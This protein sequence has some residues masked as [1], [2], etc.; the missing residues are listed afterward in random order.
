M[1]RGVWRWAQWILGT[2]IL[3]FV[4][5]AIV[6][7]WSELQAQP[8][9]WE[10]RP[11][12]LVAAA[13][14]VWAMYA[15]LIQAW[16]LMLRGWGAELPPLTAA[17]I[18]MVSNLGKY[19][20]GKVW[21]IAGMAMMSQRAGVPGWAATASAVMLQALAMG[22]GAVVVSLTGTAVLAADYPWIEP[23]LALLALASVAGIGLLLWPPFVQ[24]LLGLVGIAA[25]AER[26]PMAPILFGIVANAV[27]WTGYGA[28]L[29]LLA[30]GILPDTG[31]T[32]PAAIGAFTA[33]YVAGFLFLVAPG[34]VGV[35]ESVMVLMLQGTLGLG[36]AGALAVAS[37]LLLTLT[38]IGA[39]IPFL[40]TSRER[41]RVVNRA[42]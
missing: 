33:S 4:A 12:Y 1:R 10:L 21:T 7:N 26:M 17:R 28:A 38:E 32:L 22:T 37:R 31:L 8:L 20:P 41:S 6:R 35:R 25:P 24:R 15:L 13:C 19:V 16:R 3:A 39:A 18:W 11:A 14:L 29:W 36:A 42:R 9:K 2:I 5:R 34:G 30:A 23:A 27:A 40:L